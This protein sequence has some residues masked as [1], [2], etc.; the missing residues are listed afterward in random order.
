MHGTQAAGCVRECSPWWSEWR[1][2]VAYDAALDARVD[3]I[4]SAWGAERKR[5]LGGTGHLLHGDMM[6]GVLANR[7]ILRLGGRRPTSRRRSP[8]SVLPPRRG[9]P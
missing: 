4:A 6:A 8:T 5:M 2:E 7:L 1:L 3:E 9:A